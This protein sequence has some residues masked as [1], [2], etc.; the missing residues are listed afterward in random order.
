MDVFSSD[1]PFL[2]VFRWGLVSCRTRA[3]LW[4]SVSQPAFKCD[5]VNGNVGE[6]TL[7]VPF[8]LFCHFCGRGSDRAVW[9]LNGRERGV[10][11]G[12]ELGDTTVEGIALGCFDRIWQVWRLSMKFLELFQECLPSKFQSVFPDPVETG[13]SVNGRSCSVYQCRKEAV[14]VSD[15]P[16]RSPSVLFHCSKEAH[17][18][19][20]LVL[21]CLWWLMF[22]LVSYGLGSVNDGSLRELKAA[23]RLVVHPILVLEFVKAE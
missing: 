19:P 8:K 5:R 1:V 7:P 23:Q 6:D 4:N 21:G 12:L 17:C 15:V 9:A 16:G 20:K 14:G 18:G 22:D 2:R 10:V 11:T 3:S 13:V